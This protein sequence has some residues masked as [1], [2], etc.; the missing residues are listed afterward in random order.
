MVMLDLFLQAGYSVSVAHCNFRLRGSEADEDE[1]FV[2]DHCARLGIRFFCSR[3]D[4]SLVAKERG[5]SVQVAAREL[6]Y[7]WFEEV[8][9]AEGYDKVATAH[10][11]ND[12]L[13]TVIFNLAHGTGL[14]GFFGIPLKNGNVFRPMLFA[15]RDAIEEYAAERQI[16]WREDLSNAEDHYQRNFIRHHVMPKLKV[17]N[18]SLESTFAR[19]LEK[20]KG[21]WSLAE[22]GRAAFESR[23]VIREPEQILFRKA[24]FGKSSPAASVLW[25]F[26]RQ[27]GFNFDQCKDIADALE[28]QP[29]KR[30]LSTT[31]QLVADREYLVLS[32]LREALTQVEISE[33]HAEASLGPWRLQLR[34]AQ[35]VIA[36]GPYEAMLDY[37]KL[38]FPLIWR[39][40]KAGDF[41]FPL[42]MGGRKKV[43]DYLID[44]KVALTDKASVTVIESGGEIAWIAGHRLDDRFK[45]T[46]DTKT[47]LVLRLAYADHNDF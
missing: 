5:V 21:A 39:K 1:K 30:I 19:A 20:F 43:S 40:W 4:T 9:L 12:S 29:G 17:I 38:R 25:E 37:S 2:Q 34:K 46:P 42:G 7:A 27:Y 23:N 8:R 28:G 31:H 18:P 44:Q 32:A 33:H 3:F 47:A 26:V 22:E 16:L 41:F 13:E 24:A 15:T 11:L 35:P 36:G 6:R 14:E 45:I 10:Q